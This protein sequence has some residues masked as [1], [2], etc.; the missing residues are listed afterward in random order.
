MYPG[1]RPDLIDFSQAG[2]ESKLVGPWEELEGVFGG[3]YR[4][5]SGETAHAKLARIKTGPQKLRIRGFAPRM[6]TTISITVNGQPLKQ[7]TLDR[8][9]LFILEADLPDAPEYL[10]EIKCSPRWQAPPDE[11]WF[12]VNLSMIRLVDCD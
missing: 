2:H 11:R 4:W 1:D 12:T 9:G 5:L 10:L 7:W 3:K 6:P 8:V